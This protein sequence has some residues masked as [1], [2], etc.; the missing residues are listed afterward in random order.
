MIPSKNKIALDES[1]LNITDA[2][3]FKNA[4]GIFNI[5]LMKC[6]G[7]LRAQQI[8]K[9]ADNNNIKL[10]WG[11]NDE[12]KISIAA[13]LHVAFASPSTTYLDLDGSLDLARDIVQGGFSIQNGIMQTTDL[14]GLGV[15][16]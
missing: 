16:I 8:A 3:K 7:I 1:L 5:K 12:S 6:G 13:A 4:C 10:M 2:E 11:C 15:H 9:V 14:S